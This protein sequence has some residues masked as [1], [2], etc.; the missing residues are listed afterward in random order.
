MTAQRQT[1]QTFSTV[2]L[3]LLAVVAVGFA[4]APQLIVKAPTEPTMGLVQRIFYFHVPCA[5]QTMIGA[6]LAGGASAVYLFRGSLRA[7]QVAIASAELAVLFGLCVLLTGPLWARKAWGV[8]WQWDVRL[9]TTA[10]LWIIF[11]AALFAERY[12]GPG[13]PRLSAGLM[14]F[15]AADVPMIYISVSLWRTIHPKTSV[16]PTL[17]PAMKLALWTSVLTFTLLFVVLMSLRLRVLRQEARLAE[18]KM[19]ADDLGLLDD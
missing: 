2:Q 8:W 1:P 9:T 11:V 7:R 4:V 18:L 14:V 10:L 3:L 15:G 5:W 16:V 6:F 12:G 17:D 19:Q 13:G